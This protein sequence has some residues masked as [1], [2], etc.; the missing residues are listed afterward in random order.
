MDGFIFSSDGIYDEWVKTGAISP[1]KKFS[2][3]MEGSSDFLYSNRNEARQKT[4]LNGNPV[5][6]WVGRLNENKD[7]LTVLSGFEMLLDDFPKQDYI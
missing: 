6:L 4:G 3:I 7:P 1:N 2:E 5:L